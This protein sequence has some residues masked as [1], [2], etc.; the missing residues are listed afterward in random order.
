MLLADLVSN[1]PLVVSVA[2]VV[3]VALLLLSRF[4]HRDPNVR[5][6]RYGWFVERDRFHEESSW[7]E[8]PAQAEE[9]TLPWSAVVPK[10][11]EEK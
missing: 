7:V 2:A 4:L 5:R 1:W 10:E 8:F 9:R 11:E 6:T 3:I